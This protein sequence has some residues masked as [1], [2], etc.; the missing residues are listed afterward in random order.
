MKYLCVILCVLL[1]GCTNTNIAA[2]NQE[3]KVLITLYFPEKETHCLAEE[4]RFVP[5]EQVKTVENKIEYVLEELQ[6]G[7]VSAHLE[8]PFPKEGSMKLNRFSAH[9]A[10]VDFSS[11][12]VEAHSGGSTGEFLT[13][14]S[15]TNSLIKIP[16]VNRVKFTVDGEENEL[17][18]GHFDLTDTFSFGIDEIVN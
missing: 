1:T 12:F 8:S 3:Q 2:L 13:L 14:Y 18:K 9:L 7:P 15:I 6:K 4:K 10:V 5:K 11:E 17:L 16:E